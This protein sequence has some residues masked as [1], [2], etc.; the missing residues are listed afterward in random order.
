MDKLVPNKEK[1][2]KVSPGRWILRFV[3][4]AMAKS[5]FCA[6]GSTTSKNSKDRSS[7]YLQAH[8]HPL[9]SAGNNQPPPNKATT[10]AM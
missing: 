1:T 8:R 4:R 2:L 5:F 9:E 6:G 3:P 10:Q 7:R